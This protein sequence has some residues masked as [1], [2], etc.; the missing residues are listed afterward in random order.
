MSEHGPDFVSSALNIPKYRFMMILLSAVSLFYLMSFYITKSQTEETL[1]ENLYF[2]IL[3]EASKSLLTLPVWLYNAIFLWSKTLPTYPQ[4]LQLQRTRYCICC[5]KIIT[6]C[7]INRQR[8]L[9]IPCFIFYRN[10]EYA[11]EHISHS[12]FNLIYFILT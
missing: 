3:T 10:P 2:D 1:Q 9:M 5:A 12:P 6:P 7:N 8:I 4:L 11:C